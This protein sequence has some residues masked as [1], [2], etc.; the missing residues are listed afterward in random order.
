MSCH[1][2]S[3]S[4]LSIYRRYGS[5]NHLDKKKKCD[6]FTGIQIKTKANQTKIGLKKYIYEMY[7]HFQLEL[8]KLSQ[9]RVPSANVNLPAPT[10]ELQHSPAGRMRTLI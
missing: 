3:L 1:A 8:G 9:S 10:P 2:N 5:L 6:I 4:R 7:L